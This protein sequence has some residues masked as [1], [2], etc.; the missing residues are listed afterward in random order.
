MRIL[1][2]KKMSFSPLW[3]L[4]TEPVKAVK[5]LSRL[6]LLFLTNLHKKILK[7][8]QKILMKIKK[9]LIRSA[10]NQMKKI[11]VI[12]CSVFLAFSGALHAEPTVKITDNIALY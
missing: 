1:T 5:K 10:S 6:F 11:G 8:K 3:P 2:R 4:I 9:W 12:F 7:T